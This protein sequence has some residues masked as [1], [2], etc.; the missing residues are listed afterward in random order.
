MTLLKLFFALLC[1]EV[2]KVIGYWIYQKLFYKTVVVQ[3]NS[4][5]KFTLRVGRGSD[6]DIN[7]LAEN[8]KASA[9]L[10]EQS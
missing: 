3:I 8:V 2:G 1:W 7:A 5:S 9:C 10:G 4:Q 6:V